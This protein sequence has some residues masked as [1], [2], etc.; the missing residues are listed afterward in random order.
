DGVKAV[1][2]WVDDAEAAWR[3]TTKR[4]AVSVEEPYT[5][6]DERGEVRLS[7]IAA[8][9]ET[10][11]T[12]VERSRYGGVFLPGYTAMGEDRIARPVGLLHIDHMVGNV[13]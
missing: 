13:G 12:F 10:V 7:S 1:A 6:R 4:G 2:L 9:G 3:E 11:H 8:Y 5:L